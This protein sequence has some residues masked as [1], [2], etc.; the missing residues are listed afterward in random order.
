[1]F[2]HSDPLSCR[3]LIVF[4][5]DLTIIFVLISLQAQADKWVGSETDSLQAH[6]SDAAQS[7]QETKEQAAGL[8]QQVPQT[9]LLLYNRG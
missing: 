1:M 6:R 4:D 2:I 9:P 7:V 3:F 5:E 8:L